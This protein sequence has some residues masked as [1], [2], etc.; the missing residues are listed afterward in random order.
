MR[1]NF[2]KDTTKNYLGPSNKKSFFLSKT[3]KEYCKFSNKYAIR[4]LLIR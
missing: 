2:E 3:K 4:N 1:L